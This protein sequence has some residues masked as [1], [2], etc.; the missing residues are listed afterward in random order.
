MVSLSIG[1]LVSSHTD[2]VSVTFDYFLQR[3]FQPLSR[4]KGIRQGSFSHLFFLSK[5]QQAGDKICCHPSNDSTSISLKKNSKVAQKVFVQHTDR[6]PPLPHFCSWRRAT[7][8]RWWRSTLPAST[9]C[10]SS[11]SCWTTLGNPTRGSASRSAPFVS[12]ARH[13]PARRWR[14]GSEGIY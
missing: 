4:K 13:A 14:T 1:L 7:Q 3:H 2:L 10:P 6:C 12:S 11:T 8:G 9:S 5:F